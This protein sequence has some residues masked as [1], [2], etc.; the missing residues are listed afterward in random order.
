M[1]DDAPATAAPPGLLDW[2]GRVVGRVG[3]QPADH[4]R[5]LLGKLAQVGEGTI[6]RLMVLMPPGSAKSTY[7]SLVFPAWWLARHP[8]SA[9][10]AASHTAELAD[11]FGRQL[12]NLVAE[13]HE[14]LGYRLAGDNR[15]AHRFRTSAGGEYF[16]TG[17]NGP[18]TGRRADLV[19]IDD[20]IKNHAGADSEL[21][22][23]HLWNWYRAELT[24]RLKPGGRIVLVMTR[25]HEDDLAG[26]LDAS[27]DRWHTLRLPALAEAD[28]PLARAPGAAL[29]PQWE[30]E[31]A[32]ARKREAVGSRVWQAM[33][34]QA[35]TPAEGT[36]FPVARIG[37]SDVV[38]AES[39]MVRAWDL[40]ATEAAAGNDP[41]WTVGL[42]LAAHDGRHVV[43][44]VIR[45][46]GGPH[47]VADCILDTARRDGRGVAIGLPQDPGQAG[48]QQVAWLSRQLA[49]YQVL[50]SPETGAKLTRALPVA[51]MVEA[52]RLSLL[53]AGWNAAFLDEL[54]DFP[55]G[56][57]DDQVD[58]LSRAH[59]M[60]A[61]SGRPARR[62][63]V[64]FLAR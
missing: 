5:M 28:D 59:A 52:G 22:R 34:Q 1:M 4:H 45:F 38:P 27:G 60:A 50:A 44:D 55:H 46:R 25:W 35:P 29:W 48:K 41:D 2:A 43:V 63:N 20:P 11:H 26:R 39:R 47:A 54:R 15:A 33:Y 24:T 31:T 10:I 17:I 14:V 51:A 49:G 42:K 30:D 6:D 8:A 57:K 13:E 7:T 36:L 16:A 53:R 56:R 37:F 32:L 21:A 19:V 12:R 40:A 23:S 3:Y 9:V 62:V 61:Q 58:A 18:V 64:A